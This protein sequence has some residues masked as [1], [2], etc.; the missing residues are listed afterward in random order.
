MSKKLLGQDGKPLPSVEELKE[1]KREAEIEQASTTTYV[2][3][4]NPHLL[5]NE[6]AKVITRPSLMPTAEHVFCMKV[7]VQE[8]KSKSGI[9]VPTVTS[10][11][12][13]HT[14]KNG[15]Q[16]ETHRYFITAVGSKVNE[17]MHDNELQPGDE[18][19]IHSY[20]HLQGV[21]VP[22]IL[23][24]ERFYETGNMDDS[25]CF[26]LHFTE[27]KGYKYQPVVREAFRSKGIGAIEAEK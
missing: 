16:R 23:D 15:A 19:F 5:L 11:A 18:I 9:F 4:G 3:S 10:V 7:S 6:V 22:F 24:Y 13:T 20:E 21:D 27:L 17:F 26:I 8:F 1:M 12:G 14:G 2:D 25:C